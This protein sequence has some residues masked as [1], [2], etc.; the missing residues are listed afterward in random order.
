M[1]SY[2]YYIG[3]SKVYEHNG[4]Y[5][6]TDPTSIAVRGAPCAEFRVPSSISI[7]TSLRLRL[8]LDDRFHS[9]AEWEM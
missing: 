5:L 8:Q 6:V 3:I 2:I 9:L 1:R 7:S 4:G